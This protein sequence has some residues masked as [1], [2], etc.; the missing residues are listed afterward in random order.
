MRSKSGD[1]EK[2]LLSLKNAIPLFLKLMEYLAVI[3]NTEISNVDSYL[4]QLAAPG[5]ASAA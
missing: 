5:D 2:L 1:L 3:S 4:V